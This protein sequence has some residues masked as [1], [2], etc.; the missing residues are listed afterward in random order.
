MA[1]KFAAWS[2]IVVGILIVLV[3][4]LDPI[5]Y[6][7]KGF[8][9]AFKIIFVVEYF[10][11]LL[12]GIFFLYGFFVLSRRLGHLFLAVVTWISIGFMILIGIT[13]SLLVFDVFSIIPDYNLDPVGF[14]SFMSYVFVSI[15][16]IMSILVI[17]VGAG[18]VKIGDKARM[19]KTTG[20]LNILAGATYLI[21]IGFVIRIASFILQIIML[22]KA[23]HDF[24]SGKKIKKKKPD[25]PEIIKPNAT[26]PQSA[27]KPSVSV[28]S[29][30]KKPS[31]PQK[32]FIPG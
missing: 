14:Y 32:Y 19:A 13:I 7:L 24:P 10:L 5:L 18:L 29:T 4:I 16:G 17:L 25:K 12:F 3:G 20:I 2:G 1:F 28:N 21:L 6:Y 31:K 15:V 30:N 11:I 27:K 9:T 23:S 8:S 26:K 22:F